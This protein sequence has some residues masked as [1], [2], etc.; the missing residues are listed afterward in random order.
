MKML[1]IPTLFGLA[2]AALAADP[3]PEAAK[4][5]VKAAKELLAKTD[6]NACHLPRQNGVG[7]SVKA[8]A[9]KIGNDEAAFKKA[10][11]AVI[12]GYT[13][14]TNYGAA[15][16]TVVMP[17]HP[18]LSQADAELLVRYYQQSGK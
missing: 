13:G 8:I 4:V 16:P 18:T 12:K 15:T 14:P 7:P 2:G 10:V 1:L 11:E 6:C 5:D 3:A 17:A 9:K